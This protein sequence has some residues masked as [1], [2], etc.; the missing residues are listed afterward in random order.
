MHTKNTMLQVHAFVLYL[1][2]VVAVVDD[3]A[4]AVVF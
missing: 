4:A 1:F 3:N 2:V